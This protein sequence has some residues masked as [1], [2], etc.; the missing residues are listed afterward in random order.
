MWF[1]YGRRTLVLLS[2]HA[3]HK[4]RDLPHV[5]FQAQRGGSL[6]GQHRKT[7]KAEEKKERFASFD[8]ERDLMRGNVDRKRLDNVVQDSNKLDSKFTHGATRFA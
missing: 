5:C 6:A 1:C 8:R 4:M 3:I 2:F 7:H